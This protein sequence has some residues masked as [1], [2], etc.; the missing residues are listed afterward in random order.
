[1]QK[2]EKG[3]YAMYNKEK[4]KQ[5]FIKCQLI[6]DSIKPKKTMSKAQSIELTK[7]LD[8]IVQLK[9]QIAE[10]RAKQRTPEDMR[11]L[12]KIRQAGGIEKA[13]SKSRGISSRAIPV[14]RYKLQGLGGKGGARLKELKFAKAQERRQCLEK[15]GRI[16]VELRQKRDQRRKEYGYDN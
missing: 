15:Q 14:T 16:L 2:K 7:A 8:K 6:I 13:L 1:M 10:A 4:I 5:G 9:Q 11:I 12:N 3:L